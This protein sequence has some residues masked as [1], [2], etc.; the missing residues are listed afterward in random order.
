MKAWFTN[1]GG[2]R[3]TPRIGVAKRATILI[4]VAVKPGRRT[5]RIDW[6]T[7]LLAGGTKNQGPLSAHRG[8]CYLRLLARLTGFEPTTP[9]I[10]PGLLLYERS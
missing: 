7:I 4:T 5:G 2:A 8:P 10:K 9:L 6:R 1:P 3:I